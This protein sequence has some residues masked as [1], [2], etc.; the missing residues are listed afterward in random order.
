MIGYEGG[1]LCGDAV[2][3]TM[4]THQEMSTGNQALPLAMV[5]YTS[6]NYDVAISHL[7]GFSTEVAVRARFGAVTAAAAYSDNFGGQT[8]LSAHYNGGN[9]GVGA[10]ASRVLGGTS[11]ALSGT[12]NLGGGTLYGYVG[13]NGGLNAY[14]LSYGYG[15]GGGATLTV[16]GERIGGATVASLGVAFNF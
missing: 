6:G 7:D 5:S 4:G 1:A 3:L 15:L 12:A 16:G 11:W 8:V 14:G 2:A 13:E 9:W 10:I